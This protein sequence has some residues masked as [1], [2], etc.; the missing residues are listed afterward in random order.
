MRLD[1]LAKFTAAQKL[2][3]SLGFLPAEAVSC[4]PAPGA[5]FPG[6]SLT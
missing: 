2:Y 5:R 4:N 6:L 1:V 3:A